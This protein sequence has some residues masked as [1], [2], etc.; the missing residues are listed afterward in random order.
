MEEES[1]PAEFKSCG[2]W[3][4]ARPTA[5]IGSPGMEHGE[6]RKEKGP[7]IL[8]FFNYSIFHFYDFHL[9]WN[10]PILFSLNFL[11]L[12]FLFNLF[13]CFK[14]TYFKAPSLFLFYLL[15]HRWECFHLF[16]FLTVSHGRSLL[17][18]FVIF[19][20]YEYVSSGTFLPWKHEDVPFIS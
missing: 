4:T 13:W 19:L 12:F 14:S 1:P 17:V 7:P 8:G 10:M 5:A 16:C 11:F 15:F 6:W 9:D 20:I 18:C 2:L 3:L